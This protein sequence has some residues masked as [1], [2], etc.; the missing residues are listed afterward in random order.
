VLNQAFHEKEK[1]TASDLQRLPSIRHVSDI[2]WQIWIYK[3]YYLELGP[4]LVGT[5]KKG[6]LLYNKTVPFSE[7]YGNRWVRHKE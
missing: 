2:Q 3:S 4:V 5:R 7:D 1:R 6:F